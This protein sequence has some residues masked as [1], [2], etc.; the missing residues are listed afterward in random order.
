M[1][2]CRRVLDPDH[3]AATARRGLC[4]GAPLVLVLESAPDQ[5]VFCSTSSFMSPAASLRSPTACSP[6]PFSSS[7]V[8]SPFVCSL[9]VRSPTPCLT[10][11]R[12]RSNSTPVSRQLAQ[13]LCHRCGLVL[14]E[15]DSGAV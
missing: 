4:P 13:G 12:D 10:F 5:R 7:T 3:G 14:L 11:H 6:L 8:P 15:T 9:S 1:R 2:R